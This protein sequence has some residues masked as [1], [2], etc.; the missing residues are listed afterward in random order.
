[1]K[2]LFALILS[3]SLF[4]NIPL[5]ASELPVASKETASPIIIRRAE[6]DD[7]AGIKALY[8]TVAKQGGGIAR[9][10][11]EITDEY[12]KRNLTNA[13]S[14]GKIYVGTSNGKIIGSLHTYKLEPKVFAHVLSELTIAVHPDFQSKGVGKRLFLTL[15]DDIKDNEP[16]ILRVELMARESN[17]KA[18]NFYKTIGF[19]QEGRLEKRIR[20][21]SDN[22]EADIAMAW[23]NP[24]FK[25]TKIHIQSKL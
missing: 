22:L 24:N 21:N 15:L 2:F 4:G 19:V 11:D 17:A 13:L 12:I 9:S 18:I 25:D 8:Q 5:K 23:F 20:N 14:K 7:S 6:N 1:M 16:S 10:Y 3:L